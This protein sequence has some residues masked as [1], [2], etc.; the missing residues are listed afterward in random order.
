[1]D[2]NTEQTEA[3]LVD[4]KKL[5][6]LIDNTYLPT[7]V[8]NAIVRNG[9][10]TVGNLVQRFQQQPKGRFILLT[11][12]L[13]VIGYQE[14]ER[15]L[16]RNGLLSAVKR[17]QASPNCLKPNILRITIKPG[18]ELIMSYPTQSVTISNGCVSV[19][20]MDPIQITVV[21]DEQIAHVGQLKIKSNTKVVFST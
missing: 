17:V 9:M 19:I 4:L 14:I 16:T 18:D 13:G 11:K 6:D 3:L 10:A 15:Y 8:R 5:E 2:G 1:M 20:S 7:R 12:G 21:K